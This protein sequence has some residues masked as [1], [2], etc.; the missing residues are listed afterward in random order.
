MTLHWSLEIVFSS[1]KSSR[2]CSAMPPM[3]W[4]RVHDHPRFLLI[5]TE[6]LENSYV[7]LRV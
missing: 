4:P 2:I 6:C 7:R 5:R 1:S 3:P